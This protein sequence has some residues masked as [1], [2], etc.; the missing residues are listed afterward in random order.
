MNKL[1]IIVFSLLTSTINAQPLSSAGWDYPVKPGSEERRVTS[2]AEK[3]KKSQPPKE[4]LNSWDTETL[5]KYCVEYPL[6]H[7]TLMFN[8]PNTGFMRM[9]EQ[10]SVW[11]EFV[12][13]NDALWLFIRYFKDRPY[14]QLFEITNFEVRNEELMTL[15]FLEKLVSETDFAMNLNSLDKRKLANT[16]LQ[17][18]K[19]KKDFP[20]EFI[21]F[22]YNSSL[23]ALL[24]ILECDQ[25]I[26]P[27]DEISL[28]KFR[29]K[30]GN[31]YFI[32]DSM[33]STIISKV[34]HY[35]NK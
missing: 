8:N 14:K 9:Y 19:N 30:T 10:S 17:S 1:V 27:H 34:I 11:Q 7:V 28:S 4:L 29:K 23:V 2:Y 31:E 20:N 33:D 6:N 24:K 15:Y 3:V 13:R 22:H 35:I 21:G 12:Q 25:R 18:H 16:I 32:N 26:L 5:F